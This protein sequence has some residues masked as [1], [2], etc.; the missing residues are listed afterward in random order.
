MHKI[1]Y[2]NNSGISHLSLVLWS[3]REMH[4]SCAALCKGRK[5]VL[6]LQRASHVLCSLLSPCSTSVS[7]FHGFITSPVPSETASKGEMQLE[8]QG[9]P[10]CWEHQPLL[11]Y[12]VLAEQSEVKCVKNAHRNNSFCPNF[13]L[14]PVKNNTEF[15]L[16][17]LCNC[18]SSLPPCLD[19]CSWFGERE[20]ETVPGLWVLG[21][22]LS[23]LLSIHHAHISMLAFP[24][25]WLPLTKIREPCELVRIMLALQPII[26]ELEGPV[27]T[28]GTWEESC[29]CLNNKKDRE[30]SLNSFF[31]FLF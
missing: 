21:L 8:S 18:L 23:P 15:P 27:C 4:I 9:T 29:V 2:W 12:M 6:H 16:E 7:P 28:D 5:T 25:A 26:T 11:L 20:E 14:Q 1:E 3:N 17:L 13:V 19:R 24:A 22:C 30:T 31:P 10:Q